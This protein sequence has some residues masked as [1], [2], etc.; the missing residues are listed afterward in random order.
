MSPSISHLVNK[1]VRNLSHASE[2]GSLDAIQ[3]AFRTMST[4]LKKTM[5][6]RQIDR[7]IFVRYCL[8]E[9]FTVTR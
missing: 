8:S 9:Y 1:K 2:E 7:M 5:D 3:G 4:T 6:L